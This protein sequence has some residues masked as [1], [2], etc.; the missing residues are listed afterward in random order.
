M[1]RDEWEKSNPEQASAYIEAWENKH[2]REARQRAQLEMTI[3]LAGG[4]KKKGG[5]K[6]S[7]SDFLPD[8][9]KPK[10]KNLDPE[11]SEA[12][13]KAAL[14]GMAQRSNQNGKK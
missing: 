3:A 12:K 1:S 5:G 6:L 13:L 9:A 10:K 7:L 8:F 11:E 4:M 14:I 2:I